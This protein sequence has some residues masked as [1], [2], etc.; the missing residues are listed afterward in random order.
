MDN[1]ELG[2]IGK[3]VGGVAVLVTSN[4]HARREVKP[5]PRNESG[6][7]WGM[8]RSRLS[9]PVGALFALLLSCESGDATTSFSKNHP[10]M[11]CRAASLPTRTDPSIVYAMGRALND[12]AG[13]THGQLHCPIIRTASTDVLGVRVAVLDQNTAR[14]VVC[15]VVRVNN[16]VGGRPASSNANGFPIPAAFSNLGS[17]TSSGSTNQN[18]TLSIRVAATAFDLNDYLFLNCIVP[19]KSDGGAPSGVISYHVDFVRDR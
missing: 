10:G 5:A 2:A 9:F 13:E 4:E 16:S 19:E 6:Y 17:A 1:M 14:D 12:S 15:R 8:K 11:L 18:Q 7:R 3:V